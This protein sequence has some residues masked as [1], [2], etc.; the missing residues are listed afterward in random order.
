MKPHDPA[1]LIRRL[2]PVEYEPDARSALWERV[3]CDATRR[4][5]D[6][7]RH[8]RRFLGSSLTADTGAELAAIAIGPTMTGK[9]TVL[10]AVR[11]VLG[12]YAADVRPDSFYV[13]DRPGGTRDDLMRLEGVRLALIGEAGR[14]RRMDEGLLK[15]FVSGESIPARGIYQRDRE[16]VPVAKLVYHTN[17]L[18]RMTDSDDAVWR[19]ALIWPFEHRPDPVDPTVKAT[20]LDLEATGPAILRWLIEGCHAWQLDGAGKK[21]LREPKVVQEAKSA[22]RLLMDLLADFFEEACDFGADL[23]C[24]RKRLRDAY[25]GWCK[26]A[27][28]ISAR[29]FATRVRAKGCTDETV[30]EGGRGALGWGG[31]EPTRRRMTRAARTLRTLSGGTSPYFQLCGLREDFAEMPPRS[32]LAARAHVRRAHAIPSVVAVVELELATCDEI[33]AELSR[34]C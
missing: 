9:T 2:A 30:T 34:L 7:L 28:P 3:L 12:D 31:R 17:E 5:P 15:S 1:D 21:G 4:D 8:L 32:V 10:G 33:C 22:T 11:R 18:P 16:L 13:R 27:R 6:F 14:H 25:L 20:L 24:S 26:P 29:E 19:R 23:R